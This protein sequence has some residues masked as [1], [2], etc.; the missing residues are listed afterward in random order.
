MLLIITNI[1]LFKDA[2]VR[3]I[4]SFALCAL[5]SQ[6]ALGYSDNTHSNIP[7]S[8][9]SALYGLLQ[10]S[11]GSIQGLLALKS[12]S[13]INSQTNDCIQFSSNGICTQL[14]VRYTELAA[15]KISSKSI[16]LNGAY[17][18]SDQWR[19]GVY[20]DGSKITSQPSLAYV[21]QNGND[22]IFGAYSVYSDTISGQPF[23]LRLGANIGSTSM[24]I[25]TPSLGNLGSL[26]RSVDIKAQSY[27]ALANAL[28]FVHP[29]VSLAPYLGTTYTSL[30]VDGSN[31]NASRLS[32]LPIVF[33][34]VS[35]STL[36]L[37]AGLT[38]VY[39]PHNT[40][41][42]VASGGI[43]HTL[44]SNISNLTIS[45]MPSSAEYNGKTNIATNVPTFM[46]L[47]RYNP[48]SDQELTAKVIYR[49]E[50]YQRIGV[51]TYILNYSIGF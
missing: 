10:K 42:L 7:D 47:A 15:P 38:S 5:L 28:F 1:M 39:K 14:G 26:S 51:T 50:I 21:K 18:V 35:T 22:P 49:Q 31:N 3:N 20:V 40:L 29:Q 32:N 4:L 2:V 46:A 6:A 37:Q 48:Y 45:Q 16:V 25:E 36:A 41:M 13:L 19:L 24:D 30:N 9:K 34:D 44:S 17:L 43:Q 8:Y 27:L 33:N 11:L 23:T 12:S